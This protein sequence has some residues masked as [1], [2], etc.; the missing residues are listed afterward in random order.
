VVAAQLSESLTTMPPREI[1][2]T[3]V[4]PPPMSTTMFPPGAAI[5]SPAPIA[6]AIGSSIGM[7]LPA[8]A[9]RV[10]SSAA[11]RST[12]VAAEGMQMTA[13]G[14]KSR[15]RKPVALRIRYASISRVTE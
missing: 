15:P 6:A 14:L 9:A 3:S 1:T 5:G 10:A 4:V 13:I 12:L 2:A 11:R 8:P 7:T